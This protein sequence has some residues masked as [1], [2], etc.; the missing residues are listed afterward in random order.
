MP[1]GGTMSSGFI[2]SSFTLIDLASA[3]A[4]RCQ[5]ECGRADSCRS[6]DPLV[7]IVFAA[8]TCESFI[9]ELAEFAEF[10]LTAR[11]PTIPAEPAFVGTFQAIFEELE[12]S[13]GSLNAKY[14]LAYNVLAGKLIDK[15]CNPYQD[16]ALLVDLRNSVVHVKVDRIQM[17]STYTATMQHPSIIAKLRSKGILASAPP[18]NTITGWLEIVSTPALARWCV[19][20]AAAMIVFLIE[21]IRPSLFKQKMEFLCLPKFKPLTTSMDSPKD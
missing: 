10:V 13:K 14:I 16:F 9:S 6:K 2:G 7:S 4:E 3:A 17:D 1:T 5:A 20:T 15:S 8:A 18:S 19:R 21:A 12:A 11:A